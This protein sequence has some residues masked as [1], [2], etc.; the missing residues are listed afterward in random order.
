MFLALRVCIGSFEVS[1]PGKNTD[2]ESVFIGP[3]ADFYLSKWEGR[4]GGHYA[5]FNWPAALFGGLWLVYRKMY[6]WAVLFFTI[7]VVDAWTSVYIADG[8]IGDTWLFQTWDRFAGIVYGAVMGVIGNALYLRHSTAQIENLR[9]SSMSHDA[10]VRELNAK[11]GV[12]VAGVIFV[13]LLG[14]ALLFAL[15]TLDGPVL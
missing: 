13:V 2:Y 12:S 10:I 1:E 11:G 7:L 14:V 4:V 3:N 15:D 9:A 8:S 5:G 6:R